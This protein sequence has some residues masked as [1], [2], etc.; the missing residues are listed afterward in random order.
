MATYSLS[1]RPAV[2]K[3]SLNPMRSTIRDFQLLKR[4]QETLDDSAR[5]LN[6]AAHGW[7]PYYGHIRVR[8]AI[9]LFATSTKRAR[10][11]SAE[12]CQT[13]QHCVDRRLFLAMKALRAASFC[14]MFL[15]FASI[16][17]DDEMLGK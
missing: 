4:T 15:M 16:F 2:N 10:V 9:P 8:H 6:P 11:I 3:P 12:T 5:Q 14:L 1:T 17:F 13:R 7:L